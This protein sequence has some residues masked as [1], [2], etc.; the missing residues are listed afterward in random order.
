M[1]TLARA[2]SLDAEVNAARQRSDLDDLRFRI[3]GHIDDHYSLAVVNRGLALGL[4]NRPDSV[5]LN[6]FHG[7]KVNGFPENI[8]ANVKPIIHS[9]IQDW[10]DEDPATADRVSICHH[11]PLIADERPARLNLAVFFWE[12]SIVP[13]AHIQHLNRHFAAVL[14]S[15][16]F[17]RKVLRDSGC[18]LPIKVIPLGVD[19]IIEAAA[20]IAFEQKDASNAFRFLHVSSAFRRKGVDVLLSAFFEE[21]SAADDVELIIKTFPNPHND[22]H[23]KL[24]FLREARADPPR[25]RIDER[26]LTEGELAQLYIGADVV[27]LPTRGEGFNLPAAEAMALGVPLITTSY[28]GQADFA[29]DDTAWCLDFE[30]APSQSHV[31]SEG[32]LWLEPSVSDLRSVMRRLSAALERHKDLSPL[33]RKKAALGRSLVASVY[34]WKNAALLIRAFSSDLIAASDVL[35]S[36][37]VRVALISSWATKCGIAEYSR[38][39]F[40]QFDC[41]F[42]FSYFCDTRTSAAPNIYPLYSL[43]I[44]ETFEICSDAVLGISFDVIVV[45]QSAVPL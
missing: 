3:V 13:K 45:Q 9:M 5:T 32:S 7:G 37:S 8:G 30:F 21:F 18:R 24:A 1:T 2:T 6:Y 33:I 14:V 36:S 17:V 25:V 40:G 15:T 44:P 34:R 31:A 29:T 22:V 23:A 42:S 11:Y 20:D 16:E 10:S 12:E 28:G 35:N 38:M 4:N 39:L 27:V 19:Q 41:D 43:G 26:M